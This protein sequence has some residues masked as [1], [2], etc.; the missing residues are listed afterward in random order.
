MMMIVM[1]SH[2]LAMVQASLKS[3]Q[4][5]TD[6]LVWRH[7]QAPAVTVCQQSRFTRTRKHPQAMTLTER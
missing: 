7:Q 2:S 3:F 5:L 6:I 1:E 4:P